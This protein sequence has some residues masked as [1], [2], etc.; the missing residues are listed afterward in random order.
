M[1]VG[2]QDAFNIGWKLGLAIKQKYESLLESYHIERHAV[3]KQF[4]KEVQ[5]QEQLMIHFSNAGMEL[6]IYF[7]TYLHTPR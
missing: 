2:L 6:R 4:F 3:G 1:N 7:R 5:A